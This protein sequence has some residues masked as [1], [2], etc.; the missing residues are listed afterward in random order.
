MKCSSEPKKVIDVLRR[1]AE[2]QNR[3][4]VCD[5]CSECVGDSCF[6]LLQ[7]A[8]HLENLLSQVTEQQLGSPTQKRESFRAGQIAMRDRIQSLF[9]TAADNTCG[10]IQ[11]A[12]KVAAGTVKD[13]EV[14]DEQLP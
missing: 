5:Y 9:E 1:V 10:L 2:A 3:C 14:R 13:L 7:A 12:L 11:A 6:L 8:D 4:I